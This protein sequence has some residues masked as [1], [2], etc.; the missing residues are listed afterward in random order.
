MRHITPQLCAQL[1]CISLFL[2]FNSH[3]AAQIR[4]E[5]G[6]RYEIP[7]PLERTLVNPRSELQPAI[8]IEREARIL[9]ATLKED[10]R[11]LQV[12]NNELMERTVLES[13][14]SPELITSKEIRSS[15]SEIQKRA[16][17]LRTNLR[18]P[19]VETRNDDISKEG[20]F[21]HS[22]SSGLS[23]LDQTVMKFVENPIFQKPGVFDA[24]HS[25]RAAE[26][27]NKILRLTDSLCRLAKE[28]PAQLA[29]QDS[30]N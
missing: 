22:L 28:D 11:R 19:E 12:V 21:G 7:N 4:P 24:Q 25:L 26:D 18:L 20:L 30:K 15:L 13:R 6:I 2:I 10:F 9:L 16:R 1:S 23:M 5:A 29:K 8:N 3:S 17:R 14:H 27:V